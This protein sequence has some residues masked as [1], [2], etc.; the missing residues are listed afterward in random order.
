[1]S[2]WCHA[3]SVNDFG[4]SMESIEISLL[5]VAFSVA[6]PEEGTNFQLSQSSHFGPEGPHL[7]PASPLTQA[8]YAFKGR[9]QGVWDGFWPSSSIGARVV[10]PGAASVVARQQWPPPWHHIGLGLEATMGLPSAVGLPSSSH[11]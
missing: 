5:F 9:K 8:I 2:S 10:A 7:T 3:L 1:M 6:V 4:S 11:P